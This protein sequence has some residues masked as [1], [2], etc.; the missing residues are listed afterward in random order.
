MRIKPASEIAAKFRRVAQQRT[1]DYADAVKD[2]G[3]DWAASTAASKAAWEGGMQAAIQRDA[4]GKGV[5]KA[6]N[7]K[8]RRKVVELGTQRWAP[9]VAASEQDYAN[10]FAPYRDALE[11][12]PLP[13]RAPRGDPR[14]NERQAIVA[15]TLTDVRMR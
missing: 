3:I 12:T 9:G 5:A 7:D 15:R 6:G 8:Y 1:Q 13:P 14:N 4:F 11:R 2:P 10:G